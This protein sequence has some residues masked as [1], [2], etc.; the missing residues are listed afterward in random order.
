VLRR[1]A[2]VGIDVG[3]QRAAHRAR[4]VAGEVEGG[5]GPGLCEQAAGQSEA[6]D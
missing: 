6:A 5:A 1:V 4:D 3:H 2:A